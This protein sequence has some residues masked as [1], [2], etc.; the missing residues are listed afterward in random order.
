[1]PL[2]TVGVLAGPTAP[3]SV[4]GTQG[5]KCAAPDQHG[6]QQRCACEN[7]TAEASQA[8][9]LVMARR[10]I[11]SHVVQKYHLA[12]GSLVVC[13]SVFPQSS[14]AV[15]TNIGLPPIPHSLI[16]YMPRTRRGVTQS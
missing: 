16:Q 1:M 5:R 12:R 13:V 9:V 7:D 11:Q 3:A 8:I 10:L 14:F 2:V 15:V 4:D 6:S